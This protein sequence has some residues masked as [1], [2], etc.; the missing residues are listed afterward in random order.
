MVLPQ[1][2]ACTVED[3]IKCLNVMLC[4]AE[5][6]D[7]H[8]KEFVVK[9]EASIISMSFQVPIV[10]DKVQTPAE[11]DENFTLGISNVEP[12]TRVGIGTPNMTLVLILDS[13]KC[14]CTGWHSALHMQFNDTGWSPPLQSQTWGAV[15]L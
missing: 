11:G 6:V 8:G 12:D 14:W 9:F 7:Y 10:S 4:F 3:C 13:S 15:M 1:V 5:G 2:G